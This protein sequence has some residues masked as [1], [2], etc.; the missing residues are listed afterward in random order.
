LRFQ[1]QYF[2]PESGLHYNRHR[3]YNPD[4][5]RY[6]T[7]DPVKLA[8]GLNGYQYVPSP[9]G[10]VDPLG[11]NSCPGGDEC[12]PTAEIEE[13]NKTAH[14]A[15]GEA[16]LPKT[17]GAARAAMY[18]ANWPVANLNE[19][20]VKFGGHDPL[21]TT[22][23]KGKKIY[24]NPQT[25]IE[26]VEDLNGGYFRIYD[27]S[28]PGTRKYLSL[29]GTIPNNKPSPSGKQ[30]GRTQSEYNEVTHFKKESHK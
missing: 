3:Y 18:S 8:G 30:M 10:W 23:D 4:V 25:G 17:G 21:V 12:K 9:T 16:E 22:T 26:V 29:N 7:P 24:K 13:P 5:G 27:P 2:D 11:L 1:G 19:T 28:L 20:I 14:V 15:K 6:L